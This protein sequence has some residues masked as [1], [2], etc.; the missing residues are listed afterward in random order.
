VHERLVRRAIA[1]GG[2]ASGEHGIGRGKMR[3]LDEEHGEGVAVMRA[4]KRT[5]DPKGLLNPGK[6]LVMN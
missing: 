6:V 4:L 1:M 3:F 5:L 2:T